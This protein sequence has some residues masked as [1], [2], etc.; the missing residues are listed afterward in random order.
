[1]RGGQIVEHTTG[2]LDGCRADADVQNATGVIVCFLEGVVSQ[3]APQLLL[4]IAVILQCSCLDHLL[5]KAGGSA[6]L[7][8][9]QLHL[10]Q[11]PGVECPLQLGICLCGHNGTNEGPNAAACHDPRK[12][13]LLQE[14]M[15]DPQME[16]TQGTTT[17]EHN[18]CPPM[19]VSRFRKELQLFVGGDI[20]QR[21]IGQVLELHFHFFDVFS[22][23][24]RHPHPACLVDGFVG[25]VPQVS[26][27]IASQ[28]KSHL[29]DVPFLPDSLQV[30]QPFL[31]QPLIIKI[32]LF[33]SF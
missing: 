4:K 3:Y 21:V 12:Q 31:Q 28:S 14:S 9:G 5:Q 20:R 8:E 18:C 7:E 11:G 25:D 22:Y 15:D 32:F 29:V 6:V 2:L 30:F 1:M 10:R 23:G 16:H 33:C 26:R 19:P 13:T 24:F 27:L 17:A